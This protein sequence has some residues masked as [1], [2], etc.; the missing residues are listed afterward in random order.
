MKKDNQK[1]QL[2]YSKRL[3]RDI[4]ALLWI[5]SIGGLALGFYV[6]WSGYIESG[7][8]WVTAL[9]GLPWTAHGA[10]CAC[11]LNMSKSDHKGANG[12]GITYAAAQANN[13]KQEHEIPAGNEE[14]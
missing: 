13:F 4:R 11:Y 9:V 14:E 3:I 5:I 7:L 10:V 6:V 12:D 2:D 8:P 1:K